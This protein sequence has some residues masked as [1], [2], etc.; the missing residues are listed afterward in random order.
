V[1]AAALEVPRAT[2]VNVVSPAFV[3]ETMDAMGMD[4]TQGMPARQV[5]LAYKE[6]V[7]SDRN[8]DVAQPA[9]PRRPT[10]RG[11]R[12][13]YCSYSSPNARRRCSS[14]VRIIR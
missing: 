8:G 6:T 2:R 9:P 10:K 14:S 7:E 13:Q 12:L 5:A 4:S 1:R 11:T 3:R